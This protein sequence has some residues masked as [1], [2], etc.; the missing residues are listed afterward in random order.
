MPDEPVEQPRRPAIYPNN[1][2]SRCLAVINTSAVLRA[3]GKDNLIYFPG[4]V[5]STTEVIRW[6]QR[7]KRDG[8]Q[9]FSMND[10]SGAM[11]PVST[12]QGDPVCAPHLRELRTR[13]LHGKSWGMT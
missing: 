10:M 1:L 6:V 8:V 3:W 4:N 2:C 11:L 13:E 5:T 9:T 7:Q 12:W